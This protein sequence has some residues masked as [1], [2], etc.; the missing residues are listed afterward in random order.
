MNEVI[1]SHQQRSQYCTL[2]LAVLSSLL[3]Q[4]S[5]VPQSVLLNKN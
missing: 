2:T 4:E 5:S 1:N 3:S